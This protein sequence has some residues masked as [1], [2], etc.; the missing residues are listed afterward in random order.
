MKKY[1]IDHLRNIGLVAHGGA[2]K[3]S[4]AEAM[5]FSAKA[6]DRLG[7]VEEG[8]AAMDYDPEE[9]KR[10]VTIYATVAPVEWRDCKVNIVD[11]PGYFDFVGEVKAA[12]RVIDMSLVI[13]DAVAGV[14]VGTELVWRY[15]NEPGLPRMV[16][17]NKMDRE[18]ASYSRSL[19][20]LTS[21]FGHSVVPIHLPIGQESKF[22]GVVDVIK[23]K[24]YTYKTDGS[25]AFEEKDV[26]ADLAAE[27]QKAREKAVEAAAEADDDL[28]S[29]YLDGQELSQEEIEAGLKKGVTQG[30]VIPVLVASATKNIG[31]PNILDA[32]VGY[33]PSPADRPAVSGVNPKTKAEETRTPSDT[34]PFSALVF[35]TMADPYVGR[36]TLFRV[37]SGVVRSDS[38]FW[39]ANRERDER[40]GQLFIPRGKQ[41]E[42]VPELSAGDIGSVAKLQETVTGDTL[43]EAQNPIIFPPIQFPNPVFAVAI[44]PRAKGDEEKISAGLARLHEE[45][46]TFK[47]ER[48]PIT[49]EVLI[50]GMG[51]LHLDILTDR[52]GRKF[53]VQVTLEEPRV[54]YKETIRGRAKVEGKHKKQSGGRGQFGDVW[55]EFEP[56]P[57]QDFEFVDNV[58]GGAVPRQYIPAVEKGIR[59]AAAEGVLAGYPMVNFRA[60]LYDGKYHPVDSSEMAFKIAGSLAFKEGTKL[61]R[62]VL[63]EPIVSVE[64]MVPD[65]FMGDVIGDLNKKRGKIL[66]MEPQGTVQVIKALVPQAEMRRYA[67][68]LR[69]ITQ[70]RGT[71]TMNFDHYEDT[72]SNVAEAVIAET[73]KAQEE[74]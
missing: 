72:P 39:N 14:E 17:I 58:F 28:L 37:M 48:E 16:V 74:K 27:A 53:G 7:R 60:S 29:K 13:I 46:S 25:A 31:A 40:F 49:G 33:A 54:P 64:V 26:P 52:L 4:L 47:V 62:P 24:A 20:M 11:T 59:E 50:S 45:D 44:K 3:T 73:K 69:S 63:L 61:A 43:C 36:L 9:V 66:G 30:K 35:K 15:A 12:L 41:Q 55:V 21:T 57:D 10:K 5:L 56:L 38:H 71:F 19:E 23:M 70:G 65:A 1:T 68:D 8:T 22:Q 51:E 32:I 18:N 34:Q 2:G 6:I 42:P 67:I